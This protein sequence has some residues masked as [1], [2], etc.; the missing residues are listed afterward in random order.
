V[1]V[2]PSF[3]QA[4]RQVPVKLYMRVMIDDSSYN[5]TNIYYEIGKHGKH[6]SS[7]SLKSEFK[8]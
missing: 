8:K 3:D 2:G 4:L 7:G 1:T 6:S 5:R